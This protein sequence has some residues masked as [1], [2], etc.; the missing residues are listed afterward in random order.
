M[1][2]FAVTVEKKTVYCLTI[3]VL[4]QVIAPQLCK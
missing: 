4:Q 3:T 1:K 2:T